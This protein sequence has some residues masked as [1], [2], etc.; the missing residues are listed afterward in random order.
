MLTLPDVRAKQMLIVQTQLGVSNYLQ[1]RNDNILFRKDGKIVSQCSLHR[2]L[3]IVVVGDLAVSTRLIR[4]ITEFGVCILLLRPNLQA[5]ALFGARSDGNYLLREQQYT[6]SPDRQLALARQI[7]AD[8]VHNQTQLLK[9][10]GQQYDPL[11]QRQQ[12]IANATSCDSLRGYEGTA[13]S[14]FFSRYYHDCSW[15]RRLPRAKIDPTNFLLDIGYT[16]AFNFVDTFLRLFGFDSYKGVY[17]QLF[18]A[19]RSLAC[20][21]VEPFRGLIERRL[22]TAINLGKIRPD[23]F[24][25]TRYGVRCNPQESAAYVA[26]F[27]EVMLDEREEVYKYIHAFYRHLM[28]PGLNAPPTYRIER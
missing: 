17:H 22:R 25:R 6:L 21:T 13:S 26:L 16:V 4:K 19:R 28:A 1:L 12:Q 23:D 8:K 9:S 27:A 3:L 20:D 10:I 15:T 14:Y 18:Y 11:L 2:L 7:V 24:I 5:Y